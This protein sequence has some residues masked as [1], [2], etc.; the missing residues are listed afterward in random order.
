MAKRVAFIFTHRIQYFTNLLDELCKRGRVEPLVIYAN[1]RSGSEDPGFGLPITWDNRR[2]IS[3]P[4]IFLRKTGRNLN[5]RFVSSFAWNLNRALNSWKPDLIHLNGYADAVQWQSWLWARSHQVPVFLR[6]DGDTFGRRMSFLRSLKQQLARVFTKR[7]S[8]VFFQGEE[9]KKFWIA[10]GAHPGRLC[11]MPCVSDTEVFQRQAFSSQPERSSFRRDRGVDANDVV[12]VVSGKLTSRKRPADALR[13]YA[14]CKEPKIHLWFLGSG[15]LEDTLKRLA[16]EMGISDRVTFWGFRNQTEMPAILQAA[17]VLIHPSESD[18]WP[19]AVLEAAHSGL[20]LQLSDMTGSY[21]D[22][23]E[24]NHAGAVFRCG[25]IDSLATAMK[26]CV[27]E[28]EKLKRWQDAARNAAR[29]Y[30]EG[31]FC[32]IFEDKVAETLRA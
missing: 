19:Y 8:L 32:E 20:A 30:T 21:P 23:I 31:R 26:A 11:W 7:A 2:Q 13:A 25:D 10:N 3:C 1:E 27:A 28:P 24:T 9:N 16:E 29:N 17:D 15:P 5:G 22:W 12:F 14:R 6:G 4:E 18:P